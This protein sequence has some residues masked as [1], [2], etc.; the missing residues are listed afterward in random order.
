MIK[1]Q[2]EIEEDFYG[3]VRG[4]TLG[5]AVKGGVYRSEMRPDNAKTEDLIV[6]FL[7]GIDGQEQ[8]GV[9]IF[10]IYVPDIPYNGSNGR[11]VANKRRI[12]E[13]QRL[14]LD[15]VET[16]GGSEYWLET[17]G[18]PTSMASEDISQHFINARIKFKRITD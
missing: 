1:T 12:G 17:D 3:F 13:L 15:F 16:A 14:V 18:T 7:A 4:S 9:V 5:R 2:N 10:N 6:A 8:T 11:K